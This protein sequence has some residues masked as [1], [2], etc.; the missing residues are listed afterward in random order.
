MNGPGAVNTMHMHDGQ[1]PS[2]TCLDLWGVGGKLSF[3]RVRNEFIHS[4]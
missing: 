1:G 2:G 3:V 4:E